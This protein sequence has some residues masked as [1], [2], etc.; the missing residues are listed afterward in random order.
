M[1]TNK[2]LPQE[3]QNDILDILESERKEELVNGSKFKQARLI[4]SLRNK[5][6][7]INNRKV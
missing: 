1:K 6:A 7:S 3:V 5:Y 4:V 2:N